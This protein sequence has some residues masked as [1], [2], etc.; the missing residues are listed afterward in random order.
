MSTEAMLPEVVTLKLSEI[1]PYENNPRKITEEAIE[2]VR[3]SIEKFGYVQPIALLKGTNE[4]VVGHT[5][6]QALQRLGV[7]EIQ[8]YLLDISEEKAR[9]Y[10]LV[11]NRT[12]ELTEWDHSSLVM[13]L[14][15][16]ETGLLERYFPDVDLEIGLISNHEITA[17]DMKRA[18]EEI[19]HVKDAPT[20]ALVDVECPGCEHV[21]RVKAASLPGISYADLEELNARVR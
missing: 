8:V 16:W 7:E 12:H 3:E 18:K 19:E 10:R 1:K 9:E 6:Y 20:V 17:D 5:R 2:A 14:R 21:F 15:E 4:I 11:D 13:E